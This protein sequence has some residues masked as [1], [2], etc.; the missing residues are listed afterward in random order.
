MASQASDELATTPT[1][2]GLHSHERF[3]FQ[4]TTGVPSDRINVDELDGD[5]LRQCVLAPEFNL[6]EDQSEPEPLVQF[7]RRPCDDIDGGLLAQ[8]RGPLS[9][10]GTGSSSFF[11]HHDQSL[12]E[13][14]LML[15]DMI[16]QMMFVSGE[17]SEASVE[18]TTIIEE[19]V[20]TQVT[21]I[22]SPIVPS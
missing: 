15:T 12:E 21:E 11:T 1:G 4:V 2:Q 18:T 16:R 3:R 10:L 6:P 5:A 19:I 17:T 13:W 7:R 8:P 14:N 22:V 9:L 20:H